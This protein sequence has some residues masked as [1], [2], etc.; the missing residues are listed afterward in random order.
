VVDIGNATGDFAAATNAMLLN[1][2]G[3]GGPSGPPVT[4]PVNVPGFAIFQTPTGTIHVDLND[5]PA[6]PAMVPVCNGTTDTVGTLCTPVFT[7]S[8]V[9]YKSPF[10]LFQ[11][12]AHQTSITAEFD[13]IAYIPPPSSFSQ[14]VDVTTSQ[15]ATASIDQIISA[16]TA[17]QP[18]VVSTFSAELQATSIPEPGSILLMGLGLLGAGVIARKR[19]RN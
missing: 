8:G 15:T 4:G 18:I 10:T 2:V 14:L 6:A 13:G 5:I 17:G 19:I 3:P 16:A 1:L 9:Q 12:G 11:T 7:F